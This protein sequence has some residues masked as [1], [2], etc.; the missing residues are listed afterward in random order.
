M[1]QTDHSRIE[2]RVFGLSY[3]EIREGFYALILA[4]VG[5]ERY[6]P[7]VIGTQEAQ[8]IAVR[9]E[10][11]IPHR[12]ITHDLFSS[13]AHAFGVRLVEVFIHRFEDGIYFSELLFEGPDGGRVAL[14]ARTSD[15]IAIAMRTQAPIFTTPEVIEETAFVV[16]SS[17][18]IGD[19]AI[20]ITVDESERPQTLD[21]LSEDDILTIPELE[22]K[23]AGLIAEERYEEAAELAEKIRRLR[24]E[25][26][27]IDLPW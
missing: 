10:H 22:E 25:E 14:D 15:A 21:T 7:I 8:S 26:G 18:E 19:D 3:R 23:L 16:K 24:A 5:G 9:L 6:I 27:D 17:T 1:E 4:E 11:I 13:F 20:R 12:P 2:L